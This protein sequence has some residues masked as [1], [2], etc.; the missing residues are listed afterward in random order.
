MYTTQETEKCEKT[1]LSNQEKR[2]AKVDY[3]SLVQSQLSFLMNK[4][5]VYEKLMEENQIKTPKKENPKAI[6]FK[7]N[8]CNEQKYYLELNNEK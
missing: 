7:Y 3:T 4:F 6:N 1:D 2:E 8:E 5:N